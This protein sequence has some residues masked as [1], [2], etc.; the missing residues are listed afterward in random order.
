MTVGI[1]RDDS[2]GGE[3]VRTPS[4]TFSGAALAFSPTR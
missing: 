4:M 3:M 1:Y 2:T